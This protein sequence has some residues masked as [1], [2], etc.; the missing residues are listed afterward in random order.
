MH[1]VF[2]PRIAPVSPEM[3]LDYIAERAPG[4]PGSY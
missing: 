1:E 3:I 2:I 4:L